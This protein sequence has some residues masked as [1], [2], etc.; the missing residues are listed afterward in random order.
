MIRILTLFLLA[1]LTTLQLRALEPIDSLALRVTE[2]TSAGKIEFREIPSDADFFQISSDN[3]RVLIEGNNPVSMA[4]GLNWYLKYVA[5]IHLSWDR[6][7]APL[8]DPLPLPRATERHTASVDH[9]YYL[10]YCTYSYSMPFWNE[11]R[12]MKEIDWMALH[13]INMPLSITGIETVWRNLL[14][15]YGYTDEEIGRFICHHA[16]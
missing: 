11:D 9:R 2:G 7:T 12:W 1:T 10:N 15:T 8:P 14:R 13:G 6:L 5:N 3:G 16:M 4:V